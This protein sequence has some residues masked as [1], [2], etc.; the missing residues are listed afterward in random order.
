M[1]VLANLLSIIIFS[2]TVSV[3]GDPKAL[4]TFGPSPHSESSDCSVCHIA[5]AEKL[6]SWFVFVS[7][8]KQL[9]N[10]LNEV[11]QH[12]HGSNF[13]HATGKKTSVNHAGL[14]LAGD[15]TVT[16][17]TTCH[18]MHIRSEDQKQQFYHLRLPIDSLCIS[19]HDK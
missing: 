7:T 13:G 5:P 4:A 8:K 2:A 3:A 18:N 1:T 9:K 15:G 16:C 10:D 11:C 17:A 12:C 6:R 19:C 14:P